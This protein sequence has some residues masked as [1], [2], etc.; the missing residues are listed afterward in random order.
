MLATVPAASVGDGTDVAFTGSPVVVAIRGN[1]GDVALTASTIGALGNGSGDSIPF[2]EVL[3]TTA[4]SIPAI[5][6]PATGKVV[7]LTDSWSF[8]YDNS[9]V[10]PAG[11]YG[12]TNTQ[13][14]RVTYTASVM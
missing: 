11:T 12:G 5:N 7:N 1:G 6:L 14:S 4:G 10:Y 9:A 2:S 8:N 3:E 13:N